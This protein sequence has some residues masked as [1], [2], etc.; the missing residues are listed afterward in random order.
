VKGKHA[1]VIG[2]G[3]EGV[4]KVK[5][6]L[7]Q[8]C[9]ITVIT[10]RANR[11]LTTEAHN[12][13]IELVKT[14]LHGADVLDNYPDAFVV[15]AATNDRKLNRQLVEKGRS[16]SAFVYAAD[17]PQVSDFSYASIINI[18]GIMQVAISTSGRSPIMARNV[19][20]RAERV[21]RRIIKKTDIKFRINF[22][23]ISHIQTNVN[24]T[25]SITQS[26][27]N[28]YHVLPSFWFIIMFYPSDMRVVVVAMILNVCLI[29]KQI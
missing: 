12:G 4:R 22:T 21:L 19:R 3:T 7:G 25:I 28:R 17:D 16:M 27:E 26:N 18:E 29:L 1:V 5:G 11:F 10:S 23:K 13:N 20:I 8:G 2:G 6:L 24:N 15:L 9:E 14:T